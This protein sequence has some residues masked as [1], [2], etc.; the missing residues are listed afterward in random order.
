[1]KKTYDIDVDCAQC[2]NLAEQA[3]A[4][5]PGVTSAGVNFM[6]QR[7]TIEFADDANQKSVM[8]NVLKACRKVTPDFDITL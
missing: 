5:V 8:K 3:A 6:M 2:A 4:K 7:M 1:M